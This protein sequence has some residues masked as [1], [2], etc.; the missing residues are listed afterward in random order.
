MVHK[1][2]TLI[3]ARPIAVEMM[4]PHSWDF[5]CEDKWVYMEELVAM[6][7]GQ[8]WLKSLSRLG[9]SRNVGMITP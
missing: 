8:K 1:Q 9:K 3:P 5:V 4:F 6:F 7:A 2:E